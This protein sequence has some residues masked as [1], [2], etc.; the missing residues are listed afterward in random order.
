MHRRS[1]PLNL[2]ASNRSATSAGTCT[3]TSP[4]SPSMA[5]GGT[6]Y[7]VPTPGPEVPPSFFCRRHRSGVGPGGALGW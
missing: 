4:P 7:S 1:G 6:P 3:F 5:P 2:A